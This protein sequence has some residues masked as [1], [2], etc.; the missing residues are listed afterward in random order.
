MKN[1]IV[2]HTFHMALHISICDNTARIIK[3]LKKTDFM[4]M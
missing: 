3:N 4:Y 2:T 1:D